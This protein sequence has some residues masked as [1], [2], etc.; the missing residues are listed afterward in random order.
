MARATIPA[1]D[2]QISHADLR[3]IAALVYEE[4]GIAIGDGKEA[5]VVARL[6]RRLRAL[7]LPSYHA[8]LQYV[9][10]DP[11]GDELVH[12]IDAIAT[13]HTAFFREPEHFDFLRDEVVPAWRAIKKIEP[14]DVWCFPCATGE[15]A[16]SL[17][18][19]L[20]EAFPDA[21]HHRVDVLACDLSTKALRIAEQGVYGLSRV[22]AVPGAALKKYFERGTGAQAGLARVGSA[23]RARVT[24]ARAN[25]LEVTDAG[26]RFDVIFCRNVLIYFDQEAR[27][28][29]VSMLE[30]HLS[31]G[32]HL[33]IGSAESLS[34]LSHGLTRVAPAVFVRGGA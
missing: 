14:F 12:L 13:N 18:I 21:E 5:F 7:A 30:R 1:D 9:R 33:F 15:E 24:Y 3:D 27:Q 28:R 20:L 32:G 29:A 4:S 26:R 23:V 2:L 22:R 6:H 8:Y 34:G 11:T 19:T 16:V 31:P 25:L 10:R 17:T